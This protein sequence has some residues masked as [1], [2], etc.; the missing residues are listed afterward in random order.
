MA[1][2]SI[3]QIGDP[4]LRTPT[5][6]IHSVDDS[7][8]RLISSMYEAMDRA[9]GIGLAAPQIGRGVSIFVY[10]VGESRGAVIN[11]QLTGEGMLAPTPRENTGSGPAAAA[12]GTRNQDAAETDEDRFI[13]EGCLSVSG[14]YAPVPRYQQVTLTGLDEDG[15]P[16]ELR[17][18]GLLAACFQH[19]VDHLHGRLF[20]DR[21][22]GELKRSAMQTLRA[23]DYPS[24]H[25][26]PADKGKSGAQSQGPKSQGLTSQGLTSR[27]PESSGS[28]FLAP[29]FT[30]G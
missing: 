7:V 15:K 30:P 26:K 1:E 16:L 21:L 24:S 22:R 5:D 29:G 18:E 8:R 10:G 27:G 14:I 6:Q 2:F 28:S 19:E 9:R 23:R 25:V 12:A 3:R 4:I 13:K 17:A 11:P 20:V